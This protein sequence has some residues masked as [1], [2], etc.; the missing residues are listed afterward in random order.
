[1]NDVT[2]PQPAWQAPASPA[3]ENLAVVVC[4][5]L[6]GLAILL[7]AP[8][9]VKR[10]QNGYVQATHNHIAAEAAREG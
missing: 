9:Y 6:T 4:G 10:V 7:G 5:V 2:T 1:M 3:G 8:G